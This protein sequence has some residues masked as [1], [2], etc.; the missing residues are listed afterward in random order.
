[1][2]METE[3]KL[4]LDLADVS[5]VSAH[6]LLRTLARNRP[7]EHDLADTYFDTD[8]LDLWH[9][10][11]T[12]RVRAEAGRFIQTVKTATAGTSALHV[13]DEWE[14]VLPSAQPQPKEIARQIKR[15]GIAALLRVPGLAEKLR[16][17]FTNAT[18]RTIWDLELPDGQLI[19]CALDVGDLRCGGKSVAIGEIE[20]ELKK[21]DPTQMFELALALHEDIPLQIAN[22]SKAARGYALMGDQ[23]DHHVK[24]TP[25][26]LKRKMSLEEAVRCMGLNCLLQ[27]EA[28]VP[29]VHNQSVEGLH[30]MRVGLRR[31]RALLDMVDQMMP[32]PAVM[33]DG[34]DWLAVELG[35]TRDWDV[36]AGT[37]LVGVP[38]LGD[39]AIKNAAAERARH[40]HETLLVSLRH[41]R[42]TQ[43]LLQLN[44]WFHGR[45]W[46]NDVTRSKKSALSR[47]ATEGM[48]PLLLRAQKRLHNRISCTD[49]A[50]P[51]ARHRIRIA[52]KKARYAAEFFADLLPSGKIRRYIARLSSLQDHLGRLNDIAVAH[53]LLSEFETTEVAGQAAFANGFLCAQEQMEVSA[54]EKNLRR[55]RRLKIA[56]PG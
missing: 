12:L 31:L 24:A 55:A 11:I 29:G 34:L 8:G 20:F 17:I 25:I 13:R 38:G 2:S 10:G 51:V 1:M 33:K 35:A 44:G 39:E 56:L 48:L 42:Y 45:H 3:L 52:A 5:R 6:P 14:S 53:K 36:L 15:E 16:P 21:G 40:H 46:Q 32:L 18:R 9:H 19:E 28:N 50:D 49:T 23:A 47:Q 43:L 22:D 7:I 54:L 26:R 27:I 4:K 30:Q 41:P 37:T